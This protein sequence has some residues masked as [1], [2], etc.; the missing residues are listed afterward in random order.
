MSN[1]YYNNP[2]DY[3]RE[4]QEIVYLIKQV[5]KNQQT[6]ANTLASIQSDVTAEDSVV[7]SVITLLQ[8]LSA[9][10][11]ALQP[12]QQAI[13]ALAADIEA[14]TATLSNAVVA[15]TPASPTTGS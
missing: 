11:A 5:L 14:K 13:D 3:R 15:N 10:V 7:D 6:M 8:G 12:N 2:S 9:A 1:H 4:L